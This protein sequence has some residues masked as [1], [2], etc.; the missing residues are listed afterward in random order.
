MAG[1]FVVAAFVVAL[2]VAVGLALVIVF[3]KLLKSELLILLFQLTIMILK[4]TAESI[5]K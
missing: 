2:A 3:L 5:R 1:V 4:E